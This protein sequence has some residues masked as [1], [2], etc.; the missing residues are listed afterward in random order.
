MPCNTYSFLFI[1]SSYYV[2]ETKTNMVTLVDACCH[3]V[4]N[5][6]FP[7]I[8]LRIYETIILH[9]FVYGH[10]T[11]SQSKIKTHIEGL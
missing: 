6:C 8:C 9:I 3:S 10:E 4:Q 5:F 7:I 2:T 11:W 1:F